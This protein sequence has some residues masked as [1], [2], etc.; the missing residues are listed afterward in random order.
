[1]LPPAFHPRLLLDPIATYRR[2][3]VGGNLLLGA[4]R[5]PITLRYQ[6]VDEGVIADIRT[7]AN[8]FLST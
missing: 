6:Q 5:H 7:N 2:M 3:R 8:L 1:M 4:S